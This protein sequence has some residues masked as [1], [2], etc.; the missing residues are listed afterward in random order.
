M[1]Y[2]TNMT[3]MTLTPLILSRD[4][5]MRLITLPGSQFH[6]FNPLIRIYYLFKMFGCDRGT[7][8]WWNSN[9]RPFD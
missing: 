2:M 9:T 6:N 1:A 3:N 8:P 7:H 5:W 4:H